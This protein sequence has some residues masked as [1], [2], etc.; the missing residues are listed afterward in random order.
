MYTVGLD[1]DTRAYFTSA[2][3][4]NL[5]LNLMCISFLNRENISKRN[6]LHLQIFSIY[7]NKIY[8]LIISNG[9]YIINKFTLFIFTLKYKINIY[10]Y[11]IKNI[12]FIKSTRYISNKNIINSELDS[13]KSNKKTPKKTLKKEIILNPCK[14]LIIP[15][16]ASNNPSEKRLSFYFKKGIITANERNALI[17]NKY[18]RSMIIGILISDGWLHL[19]KI[20]NPALGLKQSVKNFDYLWWVFCEL[21]FL[22]SN[23]PVLTK[24]IKRGKLFYSVQFTL[25]KLKNMNEIKSIFYYEGSNRKS[26]KEDLLD[27]IDFV[28]LA[29]WIMGDGSRRNKGLTLCTD[30]YSLKENILISNIL[31]IKFGIKTTLQKNK[32]KYRIYINEKELN[33]IKN[34]IVPYFIDSFLYKLNITPISKK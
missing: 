33:K 21:S 31:Y 12:I 9:R 3:C 5:L 20:W 28:V 22:A 2:T 19:H 14:D 34:E 1:I 10:S 11:N 13:L 30:S 18:H 24:N 4:A 32:D 6:K 7:K 15:T 8:E 23:L 25:R 16:W 26:I 29:H 27:Y 17:I